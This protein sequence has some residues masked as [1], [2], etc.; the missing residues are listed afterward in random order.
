[1]QR[2]T[3]FVFAVLTAAAIGTPFLARSCAPSSTA[4]G[5]GRA[6]DAGTDAARDASSAP[7]AA[8]DAGE[9]PELVEETQFP[10]ATS[11]AGS[12]LL[13]GEVPPGLAQD[14]PKSVV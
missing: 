6:A 9:L 13:S 12:T 1:M 2:W 3:A 7:S 4:V 14:A 8:T 10:G 11:D 5:P